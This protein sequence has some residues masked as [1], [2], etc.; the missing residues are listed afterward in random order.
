M[1]VARYIDIAAQSAQTFSLKLSNGKKLRNFL[2]NKL[3]KAQAIK[4]DVFTLEVL[5]R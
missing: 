1:G 3:Q 5:D 4:S 2:P